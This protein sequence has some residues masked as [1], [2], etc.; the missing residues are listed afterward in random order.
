ME[1]IQVVKVKYNLRIP[2]NMIWNDIK[3][4]ITCFHY[5]RWKEPKKLLFSE[6]GRIV[7]RTFHNLSRVISSVEGKVKVELKEISKLTFKSNV[8]ISMAW[9]YDRNK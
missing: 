5:I 1:Y 3:S 7:N 4:K 6:L 8:P 9:Y 2:E